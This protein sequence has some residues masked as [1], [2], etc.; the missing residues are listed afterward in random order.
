MSL[1]AQKA[2][3]IFVQPLSNM[4]HYSSIRI[5]LGEKNAKMQCLKILN[6]TLEHE[7]INL[8]LKFAIT[9]KLH[10]LEFFFSLFENFIIKKN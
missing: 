5:I 1:N 4:L 8:Y 7:L 3:I 9:L 6:Y 10:L 2:D